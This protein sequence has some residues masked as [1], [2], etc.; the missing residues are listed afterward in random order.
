M[1]A[2]GACVRRGR[3][4]VHF[5]RRF[6]LFLNCSAYV[7]V[8][9]VKSVGTSVRGVHS[10]RSPLHRFLGM[11]FTLIVRFGFGQA[12]EKRLSALWVI[13]TEWTAFLMHLFHLLCLCGGM[14]GF[15][16]SPGLRRLLFYVLFYPF[17]EKPHALTC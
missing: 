15:A 14:E 11:V 10:R 5:G 1:C 6:L 8:F 9:V 13:L 12:L 17:I 7:R 4:G 3:D 16:E 2:G